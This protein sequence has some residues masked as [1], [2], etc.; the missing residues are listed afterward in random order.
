MNIIADTHCHTI[1]SIHAYSTVTET[2]KAAADKG[3]YAV[4]ITDHSTSMSDSPQC[5]YFKNLHVIPSNFMGVRVL[6]G[7]EVNILNFKGK[8]DIGKD[9]LSSLEWVIASI[10]GSVVKEKEF[11]VDKC[12]ELWL[13]I[14]ENPLVTVIGHSGGERY[15]YDYETVIKRF[16][17]KGKLVEINNNSFYSRPNSISNCITIAK[18]CKRLS[19]PV[20]V[21][22]DSHFSTGV[23]E[24]SDAIKMLKEIDF[25]QEL[26]VNTDVDRFKTYLRER[27][28][29][30]E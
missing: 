1:A 18:I 6:K 8:L 7:I 20:I 17:E 26:I 9:I 19:V 3:L 29:P 5:Y 16:A 14:A 13:N 11:T 4:A 10:H 25:P 12:T 21:N 23:G 27:N 28:I 24:V 30:I 15:K 2:V 22:S